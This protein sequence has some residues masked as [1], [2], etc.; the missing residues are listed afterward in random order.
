MTKK[1]NINGIE[2]RIS[3]TGYG[4]YELFGFVNGQLVK[5]TTTDSSIYDWCDDT[6]DIEK[7]MAALKKINRILTDAIDA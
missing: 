7:N 4:N 3:R 1:I 2:A 5:T 6:D